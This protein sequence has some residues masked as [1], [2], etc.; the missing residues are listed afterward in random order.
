MT[1]FPELL[2]MRPMGEHAWAQIDRASI[3]LLYYQNDVSFFQ[4]QTHN[5]ALNSS[6]IAIGEFPLQTF[7]VSQLYHIFGFHEYLFRSTVLVSSIIGFVVAFVISNKFIKNK[8]LSLTVSLGWLLSPN[9]IYYSTGFLPDTFALTLFL[10]GL[11]FLLKTF[12]EITVKNLW[13]FV[14]FSSFSLLEKSSVLFIYLPVCLAICLH[15]KEQKTSLKSIVSK[16]SVLI[17]PVFVIIS[18][19]FYASY[20]QKEFHSNVFL[21]KPKFPHSF[22]DFVLILKQFSGKLFDFY[23]VFIFI[24]LFFSLIYLALNLKK[25]PVFFSTIILGSILGWVVFFVTLSRQAWFHGYYHIPFQFIVFMIFF[26]TVYFYESGVIQERFRKFHTL[27]LILSFYFGISA[28]NNYFAKRAYHYDL[29]NRNWMDVGLI[30]DKLDVHKNS[31]IVTCND[32]SYNISLYLMNRRGWNITEQSWDY[33]I[34]EAFSDCDF[35]C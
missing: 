18:W 25:I 8:L 24:L 5:I 31:K 6:G 32:N 34:E 9:L 17:I 21:L 35:W 12:P 29:I 19:I 33:F 22:E 10:S 30:L 7:F 20:M 1:D 14:F 15:L 16:C 13:W 3:A 2:F 23:P 4:P 11:Y 28:I 26:T 27:I